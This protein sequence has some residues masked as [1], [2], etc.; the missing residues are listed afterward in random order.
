MKAR[1][2]IHT[3][4]KQVRKGTFARLDKKDKDTLKNNNATLYMRN[5]LR[6]IATEL[7]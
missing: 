3:T 1:Q 6:E 5:I 4:A 7:R 2:V